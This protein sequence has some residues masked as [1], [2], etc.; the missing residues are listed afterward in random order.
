MPRES[1]VDITSAGEASMASVVGLSERRLAKVRGRLGAFADE[2]F[3]GALVRAEQRKWSGAYLRGLMLDGKRKSIEPMAARLPDGDE[4]GLQQFVNQS[5]WDERVVRA[6][7]ARRMVS[8]L[9]PEAWIV[10]DTGF[11]KK[12]RFSVGVARQYSGTLGRV[13]NCQVGVSVNAASDEASCPLDWRIFLPEAWDDDEERRAKAHVPDDV[14][15]REKW[16]LALDMIDELGEWGLVP[17][18]VCADAGYGEVTAFRQG[19]DDRRTPY[20][21]QVKSATS[22]FPEQVARERP[23]YQGRGRPPTARYRQRPSSLKQLALE[24]GKRAATGI[25][26]REGSRGRMHSRFLALRVRPAN[27]ELRAAA[28][29]SDTALPVRWLLAEWPEDTDAPTDYWLSSLP[30]DTDLGTLVRLAKLRWRI[31]HD[32]RELKDALGLDHFEGRSYRGWHHHVTCVSVAHAF[33]TLERRRPK[34][35]AAA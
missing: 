30:P 26:W 5:P 14:R 4:Q 15:H 7:L 24:A 27:R 34:T 21:V 19:L 3:D 11:A 35:R 6:N 29:E 31:E 17:P 23:R 1:G 16:R 10:D 32:Y 18:L 22:A 9:E 13:D 8:E 20:V 33:L 12:G 28:R 25:T 2:V